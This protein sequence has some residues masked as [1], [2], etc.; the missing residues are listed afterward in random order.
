MSK[1]IRWVGSWLLAGVVVAALAT[2]F[3]S[4]L[5]VAALPETGPSVG[6]S[7]YAS[8]MAYDLRYLGPLYGLF[9]LGA[10]LIAWLAGEGVAR[11]APV[12][13]RWVALSVA[14]GV[15]MVVLLWT[16][17]QVYFGVDIIAGARSVE[18]KL[19]Q[20]LAGG[21]GG[22]LMAVLTRRKRRSR[23]KLD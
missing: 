9:I 12:H 18:G 10:M 17:R 7:A 16:M 23:Y 22:A 11:L 4:L 19:L 15:A 1:T 13:L 5:I 20:S 6:A 3:Q 2:L 8:Q 21:L 14:G